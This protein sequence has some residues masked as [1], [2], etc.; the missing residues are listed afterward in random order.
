MPKKQKT[1]TQSRL[2][3]ASL[4]PAWNDQQ[5][6]K[7]LS[8]MTGIAEVYVVNH[9]QDKNDDGTLK[10]NHTHL[11]LIY[12]TPRKLTTVA[13]ILQVAT[14][15]VE[16]G[17][18]KMGMLLYLTHK[19]DQAKFQYRDDEVQTNSTPYSD[20]VKGLTVSDADLVNEVLNGNEL[21]LL[22][23]VS[24]TRIRLAQSLVQNKALA[25]ANSQLAIIREQNYRMTALLETV[26][27]STSKIETYFNEFYQGLKE[28]SEGGKK[29]GLAIANEIKLLRTIK[30]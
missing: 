18:S 6:K 14:N 23:T 15:F 4:Q 29:I 28:L 25:A 7:F 16:Y 5:T 3:G 1:P 11:V 20:V 30:R 19:N 21:L 10:T 13:N 22:G 9:N 17:R 24:M 8:E 27:Q 2:F 26:S 12:D